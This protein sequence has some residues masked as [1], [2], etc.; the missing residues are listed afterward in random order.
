MQAFN[1]KFMSLIL[2]KNQAE[3]EI[4]AAKELKDL[5]AV[6]QKYFG[7]K[8]KISLLFKGIKNLPQEEKKQMGRELNEAKNE[9]EKKIEKKKNQLLDYL[10]SKSRS[11]KSIDV[12]LPG[13]KIPQG[14][15]HPLTKVLFECQEIFEKLGFEV[16]EGPDIESEW[17]NF[18]AL[19]IP[20]WHPAR[21]MWD[22]FWLKEPGDSKL[23]DN[24]QKYLLRTH[25]SPMQARYMEKHNP[26][27]RIVVPGRCFRF[28]ATDASHEIQF[29]QLEGLMVD[30]DISLAHL[31]AILIEFFRNFFGREI[32]MRFRPGYFPF[33][34]PSIEVDINFEGRWME[35]LGAG[36]VH[37]NVFK[38]AGLN[39]KDCQGFAFGVGIDRLA[40]LKYKINDIRL[41]Y[42]GDLRFLE[43]E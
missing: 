19:N 39:P 23:K 42:S 35:L 15:L 40:M 30:K 2:I 27:I 14:H 43:Q 10:R 32:E 4:D 26:P 6:W 25:T 24:S 22:T 36:M 20:A 3:K 9:I 7:K 16:V 28:E 21:D 33:T 11:F 41:F 29:Y 17:Y 34:E 5:D 13:N 1:A 37:P 31:K 38:N 8:G 12:S 18:D